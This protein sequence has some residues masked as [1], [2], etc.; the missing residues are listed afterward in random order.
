M[1]LTKINF[2]NTIKINWIRKGALKFKR[3]ITK[4]IKN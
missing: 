3:I 2:L 4:I 1:S